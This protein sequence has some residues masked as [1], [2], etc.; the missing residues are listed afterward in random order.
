MIIS[1]N[2]RF[3]KGK[4]YIEL[5]RELSGCYNHR[6][7]EVE[8]NTYFA[9]HE[10]DWNNDDDIY[11][12]YGVWLMDTYYNNS[13]EFITYSD[14]VYSFYELKKCE[15]E[16]YF[17][18]HKTKTKSKIL[19]IVGHRNEEVVITQYDDTNIII[20]GVYNINTGVIIKN[21]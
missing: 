16:M 6:V 1:R 18:D 3:E 21:N 19:M 10:R 17:I 7:Y 2:M 11:S 12:E 8:N 4:R 14:F 15:T 9:W 20:E 13:N 5:D